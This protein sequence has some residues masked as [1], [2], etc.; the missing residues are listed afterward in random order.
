MMGQNSLIAFVLFVCYF[1]GINSEQ[2]DVKII[3]NCTLD[4]L[5]NINDDFKSVNSHLLNFAFFDCNLPALPDAIFFN[6]LNIK[7]IEFVRT[8]IS[9]ISTFAFN[10]LD[11]LETLTIGGNANLTLLQQWTTSNLDK[12]NQLNLYQ[13]GIRH[14]D[15]IALRRYPMLAHL[16]LMENAIGEIPEGFFDFSLNIETLNLAKNQIKKIEYSTFKVL[17]RLIDLDLSYNQINFIDSYAFTTTTHLK[18]LKLNGNQL[19]TIHSKF[20]YNLAGLEYLNL[21]EN[22]LND[23]T[24]LDED[25]FQQNSKLLH[26]DVSHNSMISIKTHSLNGLK[27]L[28]ILNASH[29]QIASIPSTALKDLTNLKHLDVSHNKLTLLLDN[30][31]A[32]LT[33]IESINLSYNE[34][35]SIQQFTFTD[36]KTLQTLNLSSNQLQMYEFLEQAAEIKTIDLQN[37]QYHEINL[38]AFRTFETVHLNNNHWNCSWL[39]MALSKRDHLVSNIEFGFEFDDFGLENSRKLTQDVQCYDYRQLDKPTIQRIIIINSDCDATRNEKKKKSTINT[40]PRTFSKLLN[41]EFDYKACLLWTVVAVFLVIGLVRV[42]K[43]CLERSEKK[44]ERYRIVQQ[45][46]VLKDIDEYFAKNSKRK[47]RS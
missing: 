7:S 44:S 41:E 43:Y 6:V 29:N 28:E 3:K 36:L 20:F 27:A 35:S 17:L 14:L 13:N 34:I 30:Q 5:R 1:N 22:A 40:Y 24:G 15:K 4:D 33:S 45:E 2:N 39:L 37:N 19:T 42:G 32:S 46:K 16:I 18:T 12:L 31:F 9:T 11:N 21:S 26:L 23:Y 8:K 38:T 47:Q 25:A 10:G